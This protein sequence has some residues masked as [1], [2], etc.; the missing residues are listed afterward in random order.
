MRTPPA[1]RQARQEGTLR[2]IADARECIAQVAAAAAPQLSEATRHTAH[3]VALLA[4]TEAD[5]I[6]LLPPHAGATW[7]AAANL[8]R[9]LERVEAVTT[10]PEAWAGAAWL[11]EAQ[12]LL[13]A[14]AAQGA[15]A[16]R[17]TQQRSKGGG[18]T[19]PDSQAELIWA[20]VASR[21]GASSGQ[22]GA[23]TDTDPAYVRKVRARA[24]R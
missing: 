18:A 16:Q 15:A 13:G 17:L 3:Q 24:K 9:A 20:K 8:V 23:A 6:A 12:Y 7:V 10:S 5:R 1:Q 19:S 11:S 14:A 4:Q 22:I 2:M 21:P